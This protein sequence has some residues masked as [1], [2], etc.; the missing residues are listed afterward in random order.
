MTAVPA[1]ARTA[2]GMR[3]GGTLEPGPLPSGDELDRHL[4]A[5]LIDHLVAEHHRAHALALGRLPV[6]VKDGARP[7]ELLLGRAVD[8]VEDRHLV[9]VQRPLAVVAEDLGAVAV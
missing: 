5:R 2:M 6:G 3:L 8:L 1:I 7:V 4:A 9:W